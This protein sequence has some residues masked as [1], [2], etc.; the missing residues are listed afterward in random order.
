[1]A[2]SRRAHVSLIV[3]DS[4][5]HLSSRADAIDVQCKIKDEAATVEVGQRRW[6]RRRGRAE[7]AMRCDSMSWLIGWIGFGGTSR[8]R[9]AVWLING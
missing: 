6:L 1:M 3:F 9:N 4:T 7:L 8:R 5:A 2:E